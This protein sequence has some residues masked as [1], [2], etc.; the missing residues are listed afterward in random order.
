LM[1]VLMLGYFS[2]INIISSLIGPPLNALY[3]LLV[4]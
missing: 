2:G 1:A 4:R 3:G